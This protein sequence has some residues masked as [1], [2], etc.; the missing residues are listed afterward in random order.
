M[1]TVSIIVVSRLQKCTSLIRALPHFPPPPA[2][3]CALPR[4]IIAATPPLHC[5]RPPSYPLPPPCSS[6]LPQRSTTSDPML[7]P[8]STPAALA[9]VSRGWDAHASL[10]P[11]LLR[12]PL[13]W[14]CDNRL[15]SGLPALASDLLWSPCFTIGN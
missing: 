4:Q 7:L 1:R 8:A 11:A 13:P 12:S 10:W 15:I 9:P 14:C 6:S 2:P 5:R 3:I